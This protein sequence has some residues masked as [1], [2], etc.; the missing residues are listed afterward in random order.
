[1]RGDRKMEQRVS[2]ELIKENGGKKSDMIKMR[3][4][5]RW[6]CISEKTK[7]NI[8]IRLTDF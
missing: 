2:R 6:L 5:K 3:F 7:R 1:V 8:E 4:A